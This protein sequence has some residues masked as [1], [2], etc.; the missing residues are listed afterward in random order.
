MDKQ[1]V[2]QIV[3]YYSALKKGTIKSQKDTEK[4]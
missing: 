2:V 3:E 4:P 1:I